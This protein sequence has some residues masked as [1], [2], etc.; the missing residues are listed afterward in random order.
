M[1]SRRQSQILDFIRRYYKK[2]GMSPTLK[3]ISRQVGLSPSTVHYH[4]SVMERSGQLARIPN[5]PRGLSEA[6]PAEEGGELE[7]PLLGVVAAGYPIEAV[8]SPETVHVP[9]EMIRPGRNFAL[10]VRGD[11]MIDEHICDGDILIVSAREAA[12]NGQTVIALIDGHEATVKKL[13][14]ERT[15]VRLQPANANYQPI[16]I[17]QPHRLN[18]QGVVTGILRY[19]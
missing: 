14:R 17:K 11:S 2:H 8:L 10:R 12:E 16:H 15:G 6:A 9:R 19:R 5:I 4:L 3:E 1:I 18:I 7:L 13:Y